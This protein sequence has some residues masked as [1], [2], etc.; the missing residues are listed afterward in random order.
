LSFIEIVFNMKRRQFIS[1]LV[2]LPISLIAFGEKINTRLHFRFIYNNEILRNKFFLF[3][4][5][6]FNLYPENSFHKLILD[7]TQKFENDKDIY[8]SVQGKLDEIDTLGSTFT[9]QLPAL[10]KQKEEMKKQTLILL[11]NIKKIN[12]YVEIGSSGRYLDLLE[13]QLEIEGERFY[14]DIN[15]PG[16]SVPEIIDRG[17]IAI[18]ANYI[19]MND[20][21][22]N[23]DKEILPN[24]IELVNVLIGFHHCPLELRESFIGSVCRVLKSGGYLILRDHDC[25]NK[26]SEEMAHLAHDVF[27]LGTKQS[28]EVNEKEVRHFYSLDFIRKY[29][30]N[31]GFE[32][33]KK[34]VYQNG[35][36][37]KNALMLFKKK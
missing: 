16:Y 21:K 3:L 31:M 19:S 1:L 22:L 37:T 33:T 25:S 8:L 7:A 10:K 32:D 17:Q 9:Y 24:S 36:P 29:I 28:W 12:G 11:G 2:F 35:D 15:K 5:N 27:N 14:V 26:D 6:V 4:K 30:V 23:I 34:I 20:Y 13:E 18:G